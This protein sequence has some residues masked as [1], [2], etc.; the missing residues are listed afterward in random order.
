M[1]LRTTVT[2]ASALLTAG[3][4][5]AIPGGLRADPAD[6]RQPLTAAAQLA[7]TAKADEHPEDESPEARMARRFPQKIRVGDLIGLP[8]L[9]DNDVTLG[10][11]R[12]VV[13][14]PQGKIKLIV[15]YSRWFGWNGRLVAV[16]IEVVA[17]L[18]RQLA[19]LDM[20]PENYAAA[21]TWSGGDDRVI[22]DDDIIRIAIARR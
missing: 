3:L 17:I 16:P 15:S 21:P 13:R 20:Q 19:S 6:A 5:I 22:P 9:D 1:G 8:V 7:E 14:D 2:A 12:R 10:H 18:G 4:M 11:V